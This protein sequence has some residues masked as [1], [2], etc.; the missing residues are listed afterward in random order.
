MDSPRSRWTIPQS[1]RS[2]P[3]RKPIW[4]IF[5][6]LGDSRSPSSSGS[7]ARASDQGGGTGH[8]ARPYRS[9]AQ[10]CCIERQGRAGHQRHGRRCMTCSRQRRAMGAPCASHCALLRRSQGQRSSGSRQRALHAVS[11]A[12]DAPFVHAHRPGD[13]VPSPRSPLDWPHTQYCL[14]LQQKYAVKSVV[15]DRE[16]RAEQRRH[17]TS[18]SCGFWSA[19]VPPRR[20]ESSTTKNGRRNHAD[21]S[22][23][24]RRPVCLTT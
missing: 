22:F 23:G 7:R 1:L 12:Q 24:P 21:G 15:T 19:S 3:S 13:A 16:S 14:A 10:P 2:M 11:R 9:C 5:Q 4:R 18:A 20:P 6:C 17:T 8:S